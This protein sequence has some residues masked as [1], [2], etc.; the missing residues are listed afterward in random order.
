MQN[1]TKAT[2]PTTATVAYDSR[3]DTPYLIQQLKDGNCW[4]LENLALDLTND[5]VKTA[6]YNSTDT[7]TNAS[8]T[9][10]GYLFN[11]GGSSPNTNYGV[12]SAWTS[13]SQDY[14]YRPMI[15]TTNKDVEVTSY[16]AAASGGKAKV[17][18][19]YNYCAA[20]AGTYCYSQTS[21]S[22][23]AQADICPKGWHLPAGD[24]AAGSY[25]YLYNN[26]TYGYGGNAANFRSALSTPLS[27]NFSSGSAGNQDRY[28]Y[29]W[30]STRSNNTAM[31]Y[32]NV[33]STSVSPRG[34]SSRSQGSSV[35][36]VRTSD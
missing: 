22:G 17:G 12:S 34:N 35:R 27:G 3:D 5:D 31:Y 28:G 10:L 7:K 14:Y 33:N 24:T 32:L 15:N 2:C 4:M 26:S 23:N 6:M 13:S 1:V 20:S 21:S 36:C 30:S 18:V 29:F 9:Q 16:G 11:G 25:Y 19:Y 8:Y